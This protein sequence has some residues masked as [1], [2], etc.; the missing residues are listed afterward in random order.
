[1]KGDFVPDIWQ[2]P[3][4]TKDKGIIIICKEMAL[5]TCTSIASVQGCLCGPF[6]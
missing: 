5:L 1:M 4:G 3:E 6:S 2:L